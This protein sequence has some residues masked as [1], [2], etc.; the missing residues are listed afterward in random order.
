MR[1]L[2]R[3]RAIILF[4][5]L[6][7]IAVASTS[8]AQVTLVNQYG[9]TVVPTVP[10]VHI[11][12]GFAN[13]SS[14]NE[15]TNAAGSSSYVNITHTFTLGSGSS[16]NLTGFLNMASSSPSQFKYLTNVTQFSGQNRVSSVTLF[17]TGENSSYSNDFTYNST[18]G[19]SNGTSPVSISPG[20]NS[21]LGLFIK[22]GKG[23]I[24]EDSWNLNF[25]VNGYVTGNGSSPPVYTQYF[26]HIRVTTILIA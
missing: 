20:H 2:L 1:G 18:A 19:Y 13:T 15:S 11:S 6:I 7:A 14:M 26:V 8:V 9:A 21:A 5:A 3:K 10:S 23:Q 25:E 12:N 22:L 24:G 16:L 17:S 4:S